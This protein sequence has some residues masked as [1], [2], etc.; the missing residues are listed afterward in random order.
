MSEISCG[1]CHIKL[2]LN[3]PPD[4]NPVMTDVYVACPNGHYFHRECLK[5]WMLSS[6]KCPLCYTPFNPRIIDSFQDYFK[7]VEADKLLQEQIERQLEEERRRKEEM[8]KM[9]KKQEVQNVINQGM[10]LYEQ[11]KFKEA[12][13]YIWDYIDSQKFDPKDENYLSLLFTL[14]L[15]YYHSGKY[16]LSVQQLMKIVKEDPTFPHAFKYL[17]MNYEKLGMPDKAKWAKERIANSRQTDQSI[18]LEAFRDDTKVKIRKKG[19]D[20]DIDRILNVFNSNNPFFKEL[21]SDFPVPDKISNPFEEIQA[22][23]SILDKYTPEEFKV[24][25]EKEQKKAIAKSKAK[26]KYSLSDSDL[27]FFE[28]LVFDESSSSSMSSVDSST[29]QTDENLLQTTEQPETYSTQN[30]TPESSQLHPP[31]TSLHPP[32]TSQQS[33]HNETEELSEEEFFS[34]L[35]EAELDQALESFEELPPPNPED[36][37]QQCQNLNINP[38]ITIQQINSLIRETEFQISELEKML[39]NLLDAYGD[40]VITFDKLNQQEDE[41][42]KYLNPLKQKLLV[43]KQLK[44]IKK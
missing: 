22:D 16:A 4:M 13:N 20:S 3:H 40:G 17:E 11:K 42:K 8:Q 44:A 29:P 12:I 35:D 14:A 7:Q 9:R 33:L 15:I 27:E 19:G 18:L 30:Q 28:K 6:D 38:N 24:Q 43:L 37:Y 26:A 31:L 34:Y 1:I 5:G 41:L 36:V 32:P 25:M 23:E 2:V 39:E 21:S 10:K